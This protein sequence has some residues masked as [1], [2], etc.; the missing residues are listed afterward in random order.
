MVILALGSNVLLREEFLTI[1]VLDSLIAAR[2]VFVLGNMILQEA[3]LEEKLFFNA[4]RQQHVSRDLSWLCSV[5]NNLSL[6]SSC[7]LLAP[8][9][10]VVPNAAGHNCQNCYVSILAAEAGDLYF[11]V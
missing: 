1:W 10:C 3:F 4:K 11:A 6:A 5:E 7:L 9:N 2:D 8:C